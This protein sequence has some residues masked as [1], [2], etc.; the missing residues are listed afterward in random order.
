MKVIKLD[1]GGD[2]WKQIRV[3]RPT[4]SRFSDILTPKGELSKSSKGY[5]RELI[6]QTFCPDFEY[7]S[8]NSFTKR[9]AEIEPESRRA[10]CELTGETVEEVGF[11]ISD[12]GICGCSPD[13]LLL[14]SNGEFKSGL[15]LKNGTPKTHIGWVAD[16]IL[17]DE[18]KA[19][20]HGSMAVTGFTEWHFFSY[21]PGMK[22]FHVLVQWDDYTEKL[23]DSLAAFVDEYKAQRSILIPK[24][25]K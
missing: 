2:A 7:W 1:Q 25:K 23:K 13:G 16:G 21:F 24:L 8:G 10:F 15:E 19:Q 9:G 22:P 4:A 18:H 3:G 17:P 14:D 20:V 5:I 11:V 6:G 12:D